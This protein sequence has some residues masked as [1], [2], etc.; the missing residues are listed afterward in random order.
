MLNSNN[1]VVHSNLG[2]FCSSV[3]ST[4]LSGDVL[5][6]SGDTV[7]L[8]VIGNEATC[9][10]TVTVEP[11]IQLHSVTQE[12]DGSAN[13]VYSYDGSRCLTL[14]DSNFNAVSPEGIL[15]QAGQFLTVSLN[16]AQFLA[17]SGTSV[18]LCLQSSTRACSA[19]AVVVLECPESANLRESFAKKRN[20]SCF[21]TIAHCLF[22]L[23]MVETV[24]VTIILRGL[25]VAQF[26]DP[27][28]VDAFVQ[29][30]SNIREFATIAF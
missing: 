14:L 1:Q 21:C 20:F 3:P 25:S 15:C 18:S 28:T 23:C 26:S 24:Q 11:K 7:R 12:I 27:S 9:S 5:V 8:C 10:N 6:T 29:V 17:D 13:I 2:L 16:S 30:W 22:H 4:V 19:N